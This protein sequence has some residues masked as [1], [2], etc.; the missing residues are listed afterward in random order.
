MKIALV[1]C[2]IEVFGTKKAFSSPT[3]IY[4]KHYLY[5][6]AWALKSHSLEVSSQFW[7]LLIFLGANS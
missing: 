1:V 7:L 6:V 3:S 5:L 4:E 2:T